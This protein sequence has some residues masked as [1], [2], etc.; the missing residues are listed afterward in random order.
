M[1]LFLLFVASSLILSFRYFLFLFLK[2]LLAS[3]HS[4]FRLSPF[5]S[6]GSWNHCNLACFLWSNNFEH[7]SFNHDLYFFNSKQPRLSLVQI[8]IF[9]LIVSQALIISTSAFK[10]SKT[11]NLLETST[12][13]CS[14]PST[15]F[16]FLRLNLSTWNLCD[17]CL[18]LVCP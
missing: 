14:L 7:P 13:N 5:I 2:C 17:L 10:F 6:L 8:F 18:S 16:N 15:S 4:L 1:F 12:H 3:R 9:S 11:A